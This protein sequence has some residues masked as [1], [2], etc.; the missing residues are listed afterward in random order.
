MLGKTRLLER[1]GQVRDAAARML[2]DAWNHAQFEAARTR[3]EHQLDHGRLPEAFDGAQKLLDRARAGGETAYPGADYDLGGACWLGAR[4]LRT[5]GDSEHALALLAEAR[6]RFEAVAKE[7]PGSGAEQMTFVCITERGD[8]LRDL[9]RLDQA[10]AA[11]EDAS[12]RAEQCGASRDVAVDKLKLGSVRFLQRRNEEALAAYTEARERFTDLDEPGTVASVW[13]RTGKV[14]QEVGRPEEAED[15]YRKSLAISVRLGDLAGQA[16]TLG[17]LGNFYDDVLD[18]PEDAVGFYRQSGEK[19]AE[20]GDAANEGRTSHNL[21]DALRRLSRFGEARREVLR[22]I[23]CDA[24]F[25]HGSE[26]WK[27][28]DLLAQIETA[29][30]N[31]AASAEARGKTIAAY[32]AYRR[33]GGENHFP[34]GRVAHDVTQSLLAGDA[35]SVAA[36]LEGLAANPDAAWLRPF[37]EALQAIVA[38]S[39]DRTLAEAP[40]MHYTMAVEILLLIETLESPRPG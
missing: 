18:R 4:V 13:F 11:Y 14:L 23:E 8:C 27:T 16:G 6:R 34:Y 31:P 33:D 25:G 20:I 1:V 21:A 12:R 2:G 22:A 36:P 35:A 26:P 39:R 19:Y 5:A 15:A 29:S 17:Q 10:A 28:W 9:G 30:G 24:Q 3:I 40:G 37:I 38:G 32:M 7:R